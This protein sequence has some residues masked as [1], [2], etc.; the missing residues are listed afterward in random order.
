MTSET[1]EDNSSESLCEARLS[2]LT[3]SSIR[4]VSQWSSKF[5]LLHLEFGK[6][7]ELLRHP[8]SNRQQSILSTREEKGLYIKSSKSV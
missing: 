5:K 6:N 7:N 1:V 8:F 3:L 2:L 4:T